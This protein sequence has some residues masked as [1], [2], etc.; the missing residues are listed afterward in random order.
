MDS[1]QFRNVSVEAQQNGKTFALIAREYPS[2]LSIK[3]LV[4][5]LPVR[6]WNDNP[7]QGLPSP[8]PPPPSNDHHHQALNSKMPTYIPQ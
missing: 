4:I 3:R 2:Y 8:S 5:N 6:E 7:L 1:N